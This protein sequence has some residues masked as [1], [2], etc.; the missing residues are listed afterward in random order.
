MLKVHIYALRM[1]LVWGFYHPDQDVKLIN[2]WRFIV[3]LI[4]FGQDQEL[5]K[6]VK[7]DETRHF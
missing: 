3:I 5:I 4:N 1:T 6:I 7:N 2:L